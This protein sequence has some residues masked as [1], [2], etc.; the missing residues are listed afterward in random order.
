MAQCSR[1][2]DWL[3]ESCQKAHAICCVQEQRALCVHSVCLIASI[4]LLLNY[5]MAVVYTNCLH[6]CMRTTPISILKIRNSLHYLE[7]G[8]QFVD[9]E[10]TQHNLKITQ[11]PEMCGTYTCMFKNT[12]TSTLMT[13]LCTYCNCVPSGTIQSH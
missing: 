13:L 12:C 5:I 11:I 6:K 10:F 7:I 9:L 4:W 3:H 2:K 8:M 1:C